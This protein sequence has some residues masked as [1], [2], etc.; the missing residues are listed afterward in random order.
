MNQLI[1]QYAIVL[2]L[3]AALLP[4]GNIFSRL[5]KQIAE[6]V[7]QTNQNNSLQPANK[8]GLA[9][10]AFPYR[11][12]SAVSYEAAAKAAAVYDLDSAQFLYQK[13]ADEK[14]PIASITK[15]ATALVILNGHQLNETITIPKVISLPTD[16]E[17]VGLKA[18]E[19]FSLD[20][21]LRAMLISSANDMAESL[22][23]WD[24][25][26]R[27][28]FITK[29]NNQAKLWGLKNTHFVNPTGLDENNHYS[30]ASDLITL[31]TILMQNDDFRKIVDTPSYTAKNKDGK[32]YV[33]TNTN[34][35]LGY[36]YIH[37][38][39]TGFTTEAGQTLISFAQKD[40]HQLLAVVLNSP[41]RFQESKNML[42]WAFANHTWK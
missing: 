31:A 35:L 12:E 6:R 42:D 29:M 9:Y 2:T 24:T 32:E 1:S 11:N 26:S 8:P 21:A 14:M 22:A 5:H 27:G 34:K 17:Q 10:K 25:G 3:L 7:I 15:I 19:K 30:S 40:N 39:K 20:E 37:G 36:N 41:D 4:N 13:K 18:G 38:I 28:K 33:L 16:G 23:T